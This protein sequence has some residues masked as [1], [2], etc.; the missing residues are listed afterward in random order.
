MKAGRKPPGANGSRAEDMLHFLRE[1]T[2]ASIAEMSARFRVSGMTIRRNIERLVEAG[3]VIRIP[4]GAR[5]ARSVAFEKSFA[6]RLRKMGDAKN[7]IGRAAAALV[8]DGEALVLD[9]GTTTLCLARHLRPRRNIVVVTFSVAALEE[10]GG[11]EGIRVELTGGVYR[12][13]SHDLIGGAVDQGLAKVHANKVFFGAAALSFEKGIM[14]YDGEAPRALINS[15]A[16]RILVL[17]SSKIGVEAL[18]CL[19]E[20]KQC[21]LVITDAGV[22]P[23]DLSR[24]RKL[25]SVLVAE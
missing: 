24:L 16:Q 5:L 6:E 12:R 11:C 20:L 4:G 13:S 18:Y 10:L 17:D 7:R 2:S 15:G 21:D 3:Q 14:L 23:K 9:S 1:R 25:T 22:K 8:K 19:C